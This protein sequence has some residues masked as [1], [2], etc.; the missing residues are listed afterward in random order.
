MDML[1]YVNGY[2]GGRYGFPSNHASNGFAV[3]TFL[4]LLYRKPCITELSTP[5]E[6]STATFLSL[7]SLK[8]MPQR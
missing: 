6:S 1:S 2:R 3:A 5:P 4:A 8:F 7:I